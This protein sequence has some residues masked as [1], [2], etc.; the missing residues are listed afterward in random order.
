MNGTHLHRVYSHH[1]SKHSSICLSNA[2]KSQHKADRRLVESWVEAF[3]VLQHLCG[4]FCALCLYSTQLLFNRRQ[5]IPL[6]E[7]NCLEWSTVETG[8]VYQGDYQLLVVFI[9]KLEMLD[10]DGW[11]SK[12]LIS[13]VLDSCLA[14]GKAASHLSASWCIHSL[15]SRHTGICKSIR[16]SNHSIHSP[17]MAKSAMTHWQWR[18]KLGQL[19]AFAVILKSL[20]NKWPSDDGNY[21]KTRKECDANL[22][23]P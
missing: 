10:F 5:G 1:P 21:Q 12:F 13:L 3:S 23:R 20:L 14:K 19:L 22:T 4:G 8:R 2:P 7:W 17:L 9:F 16:M 15:L 11:P 18:I 6:K